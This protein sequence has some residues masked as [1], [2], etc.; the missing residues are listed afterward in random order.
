MRMKKVVFQYDGAPEPT[1]RDVNVKLS[2][3]S[4]VGIVGKNGAGKTTLLRLLI[5]E[6]Q[7]KPG[8]GETWRHHNLRVAYIAQH[9]HV[10]IGCMHDSLRMA[11]LTCP[12]ALQHAPPDVAPD[13]DPDRVH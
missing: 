13:A 5:G 3:G 12:H 1:L 6:L 8:V 10:V 4:R 7:P 2:L 11:D 9:R